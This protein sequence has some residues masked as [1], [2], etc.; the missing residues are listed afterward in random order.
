[1]V[2]DVFNNEFNFSWDVPVIIKESSKTNRI[3]EYVIR[4]ILDLREM[5]DYDVSERRLKKALEILK[6]NTKLSRKSVAN[7]LD[8]LLFK[9]ILAGSEE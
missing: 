5:L 9:N 8:C 2:T 1:M 4:F 3:P 7:C 6:V